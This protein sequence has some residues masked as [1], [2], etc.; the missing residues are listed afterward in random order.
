MTNP[1][2]KATN[3]LSDFL[4][5]TE[6]LQIARFTADDAAFILDLVNTPSWLAFIGDRGVKTIDD[7][8]QYILNG[9]LM[10][11]ETFGFGSYLVK[12]KSN[13]IS[14]G[15]C[16]LLKR[17]TLEDIDIGF[18][19]LPDYVGLGY[20]YEAAKAVMTYAHKV[21]NATRIVGITHPDNQPSIRLL[22]KLGL[23][24]ERTI[25]LGNSTTDSL[26]F[27]TPVANL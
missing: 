25:R 9:P 5:E 26:L 16:G 1:V 19:F 7:A 8:Q 22:E 27:G 24:F 4:L 3:D 15:M 10:S 2:N 14:V 21:L 20:G 12:L 23:Q 6:R 11:Y 17:D 18:A 13:G